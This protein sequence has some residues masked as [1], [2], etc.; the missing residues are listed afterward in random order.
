[1][2]AS[3]WHYV[4]P[5]DAD[6]EDALQNLRDD[7]FSSGKYGDPFT[8]AGSEIWRHFWKMPTAV[9]LV[10]LAAKAFYTIDRT[11]RWAARGFR[12]PRSIEE[13]VELAAEAGTHSILD[14]D[15]CGRMPDVGLAAP[16][17]PPRMLQMFGTDKPTMEDADRIITTA[18]ETMELGHCLYF[19]L[20]ED[21]RPIRLV[22][23][24]CSGD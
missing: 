13:A 1:M 7:V 20:Y 11:V 3:S 2:G 24:G 6:P 22:F 5:Y 23:V 18:G 12:G 8:A 19:C 21:G 15:H 4:V 16:L 9:K 17:S 14:I 10:V